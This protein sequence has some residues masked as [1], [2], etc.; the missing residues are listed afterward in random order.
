MFTAI[1][2]KMTIF[3]KRLARPGSLNFL[4]FYQ[5]NEI[6]YFLDEIWQNQLG[7]DVEKSAEQ[8]LEK[9]HRDI[10]PH[11]TMWPLGGQQSNSDI[12]VLR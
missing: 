9:C 4:I 12:G 10:A 5:N 1:N 7:F 2:T 8:I 11:F 3:L 6:C